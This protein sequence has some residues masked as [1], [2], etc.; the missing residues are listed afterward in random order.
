M[1]ACYTH[2]CGRQREVLGKLGVPLCEVPPRGHHGVNQV[3]CRCT[4]LN[5]LGKLG[6]VRQVALNDRHTPVA[7]P[8]ALFERARFT[9]NTADSIPTLEEG[10]DEPSPHVS[11]RPGDK[12]FRSLIDLCTQT[13]PPRGARPK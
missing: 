6:R 2:C 1:I 7:T 11:R 8:Y 5:L 10:W 4:A 9:H 12:Y 3:I 13:V